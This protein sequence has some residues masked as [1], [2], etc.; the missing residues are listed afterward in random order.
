MRKKRKRASPLSEQRLRTIKVNLK[1]HVDKSFG[2]TNKSV[3]KLASA[4]C[5]NYYRGLHMFDKVS[6]LNL[7][8]KSPWTI[9]V[10]VKKHFVTI[11]MRKQYI[12]YIDSFGLPCI[13]DDVC[14]F[15]KKFRRD[16][17]YNKKRIQAV[18]SMHCGLYALL[19]ALYFDQAN[20][21]RSRIRL[22]FNKKAG[23]DNDRLCVSYL[24]ALI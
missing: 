10:N 4:L 18:D 23:P 22:Q 8:S 15:L 24:S 1:K 12:F 5:S 19:F 7:S 14:L 16:V 2:M 21:E 13:I 3:D 17:F 20:I 11:H 9:I 6:A